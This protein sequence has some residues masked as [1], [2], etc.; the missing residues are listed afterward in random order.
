MAKERGFKNSS[1][2]IREVIRHAWNDP[3]FKA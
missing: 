1:Q 3:N 2:F